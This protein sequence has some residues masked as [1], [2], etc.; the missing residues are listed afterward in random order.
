MTTD[1]DV[2]YGVDFHDAQQ[3][4]DWIQSVNV[5]R[6]WRQQVFL[7]FAELVSRATAPSPTVLELGGGPGFLAHVVLTHCPAIQS[8]T[9]L[10][11]A[12]PMLNAAEKRLSRFGNRVSF[13]QADFR[14]LP[15]PFV[16][17]QSFDFILSLQ[18][19]HELRHKRHTQSLYAAVCTL[20]KPDGVFLVADH[21]P[22]DNP[23]NVRSRLYMTIDENRD[24]LHA[25]GFSR[26][27]LEHQFPQMPLLSARA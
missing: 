19:V 2:P 25:A 4:H 24:T 13:R 17:G 14:A 11:F 22:G 1:Q 26:V 9:V 8:Y 7:R 20:L 12:R 5:K 3:T 16:Q 27:K 23:T 18:A 6:P 15:E 10:D 21:L